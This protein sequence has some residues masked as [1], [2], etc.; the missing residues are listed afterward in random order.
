MNKLIR[1]NIACI[2]SLCRQHHIKRLFVFGSVMT[3][4]FNDQSDVDF[5]YEPDYTGFDL[6]DVA[7]YPYD[8]FNEFF[9]L[10]ESLENLLGRKV[11]LVPNGS[12]RNPYFNQSVQA[13]KQLLYHDERLT[14]VSG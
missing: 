10:K 5:L 3:H 2:K 7:S 11:D 8:P 4:D 6:N 1:D 13:T 9:E 12:F 14:E